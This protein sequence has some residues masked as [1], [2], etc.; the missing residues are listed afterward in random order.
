MEGTNLLIISQEEMVRA[1]NKYLDELIFSQE[2]G[3]AKAISVRQ[4][5]AR[6][7]NR[8]I[9]EIQNPE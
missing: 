9:I 6:L 5:G 3:S 7:E 1:I 8:F 4:K 2:L